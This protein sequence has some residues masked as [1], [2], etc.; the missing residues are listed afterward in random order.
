LKQTYIKKII[1][2]NKY[3]KRIFTENKK[4]TK[5]LLNPPYNE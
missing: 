4:N 3:D 1:F 2:L 5:P